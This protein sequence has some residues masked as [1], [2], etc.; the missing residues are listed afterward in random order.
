[1]QWESMI[2][3]SDVWAMGMIQSIVVLRMTRAREGGNFVFESFL[4]LV[5][6]SLST[7]T[8][9]RHEVG[10]SKQARTH[11]SKHLNPW[12]ESHQVMLYMDRAGCAI[13]TA[14]LRNCDKSK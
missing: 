8:A 10:V 13:N 5:L 9:A 11:A 3:L 12:Y 14:K 1:M 7:K 4:V 6:P 2:Y